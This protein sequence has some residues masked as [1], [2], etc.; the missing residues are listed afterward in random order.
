M[1]SNSHVTVQVRE[2]EPKGALLDDARSLEHTGAFIV[3]F[4]VL[5]ALLV[6]SALIAIGVDSAIK[7]WRSR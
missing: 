6:G 3:I 7:K 2:R 4:V 1:A 5:G